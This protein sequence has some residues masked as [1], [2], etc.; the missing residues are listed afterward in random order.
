MKGLRA[1]LLLATGSL[2]VL[3][4]GLEVALRV[5]RPP[6][7]ARSDSISPYG[8]RYL[9]DSPFV[10]EEENLV[11]G[12]TN[13]LGF[14][15]RPFAPL[16]AEG[17]RRIAFFGDSFV[18]AMQVEADSTFASRFEDLARGA[19][20]PLD[21]AAFG[22][23]GSGADQSFFR[24]RHVLQEARIDDVVYVF[25]VNDFFDGYLEE[26]KPP[27]WPFLK[28]SA[29]GA[30]YFSG[31]YQHDRRERSLL[32]VTKPLLAEFYLP[33]FV[34]YRLHLARMKR[35]GA[36][37][38]FVEATSDSLLG[39]FF[40]GDAAPERHLAAMAHWGDV[41][42][43]WR[44]TCAA[45]GTSF[46]I[47]YIPP[48][49]EADDSTFAATFGSALPRHGLAE[50]M[51]AF[52]ERERIEFLDPT[53]HFIA[54]GGGRGR[55]LYWAHLNERGHRALSEFLLAE[56]RDERR[57]HPSGGARESAP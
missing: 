23:S 7:G 25:F 6:I 24:C 12:R 42:R 5:L 53:E 13:A 52:C 29:W 30:S 39:L 48:V 40:R 49:W 26:Q 18:E 10:R 34:S 38:Q 28:R 8:A 22:I 1:N 41:V 17:S 16:G 54:S 51:R 14:H 47:L 37:A 57:A 2:L 9:P 11:R 32:S 44:S 43:A 19:G 35:L 4:T 31:A 56:L 55:A 21:V 36:A 15:D 46:R 27:S 3:A 33:A 50:W 20:W 45:N